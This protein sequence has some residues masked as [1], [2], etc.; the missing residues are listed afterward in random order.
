MLALLLILMVTGLCILISYHLSSDEI[1][2]LTYYRGVVAG[3]FVS[4]VA[5]HFWNKWR[6]K[7]EE[8]EKTRKK[9]K[10]KE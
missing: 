5:L 8:K 1:T 3:F 4:G 7:K 9:V 2:W 10:I 6:R